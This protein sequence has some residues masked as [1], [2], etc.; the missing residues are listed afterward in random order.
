MAAGSP[1][2]RAGQPITDP[3]ATAWLVEDDPLRAIQ[4]GGP[5]RSPPGTGFADGIQRWMVEGHFGLA[6][7]V[8]A[9]VAAAVLTRRDGSLAMAAE[10]HEEFIVVPGERL[11][12]EQRDA[13][14]RVGLPVYESD[15]SARV[16]P[17]VD[18][19]AAARIVETRRETAERKTVR[20][21]VDAEPTSWLVMDGS[22]G[23][24]T[25]GP[26]AERVIG[27]VK[28][29]ETQY[30][31]GADLL[32]ALT[33]REGCRS[34]VFERSRTGGTPVY[35]WYLRLWPWTERDLLHGLTRLERWAD[36]TTLEEATLVSRWM[37]GE[38][39]PI[40]TPDASW[41]RLIYP[42][43]HVETYLRARMG[44]WN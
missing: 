30:L 16:H 35:S 9:Y 1:H 31:E 10:E 11:T 32:T 40:S 39:A 41:D 28:S 13:L 34:S 24:L 19:Y 23:H 6:P 26:G 43:H 17:L 29:H 14:D 7:V 2:R 12:T 25:G 44:G 27:L 36:R 3:F 5:L 8:R 18:Q 21:F 4:V 38:R 42:I 33:L 20:R 22:V 15:T 37:L